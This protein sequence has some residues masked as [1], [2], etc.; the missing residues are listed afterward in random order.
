MR[1]VQ[2]MI[3]GIEKPSRILEMK[4]QVLKGQGFISVSVMFVVNNCAPTTPHRVPALV[5][6]GRSWV[7]SCGV[8]NI[9]P[10]DLLGLDTRCSLVFFYAKLICPN[11][12]MFC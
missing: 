11:P 3:L 8:P 5:V 9:L 6:K 10:L 7:L 2:E 1:L 4:Q 12:N